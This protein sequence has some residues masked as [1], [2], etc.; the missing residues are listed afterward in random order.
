VVRDSAFNA[1]LE[2]LLDGLTT[3]DGLRLD[4]GGRVDEVAVGNVIERLGPDDLPRLRKI[5]GDRQGWV[6]E[7]GLLW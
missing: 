6:D 4:C 3:L 5:L 7:L 2:E 1:E